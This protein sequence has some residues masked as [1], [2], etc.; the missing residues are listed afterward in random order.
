M[1][2]DFRSLRPIL[3][4]VELWNQ[5]K[6]MREGGKCIVD[7]RRSWCTRIGSNCVSTNTNTHTHF[8]SE[9][10]H[11][12]NDK[13]ANDI[14][15]ITLHPFYDIPHEEMLLLLCFFFLLM[16]SNAIFLALHLIQMHRW[17]GLQ[18]KR[19]TPSVP[20]VNVVSIFV[21]DLILLLFLS[22]VVRK[23]EPNEY[24]CSMR[25]PTSFQMRWVYNG[26][27]CTPVKCDEH[28]NSIIS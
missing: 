23:R 15:N 1:Q 25:P 6:A 28:Q 12:T 8:Q 19:F 21:Y 26:N 11:S 24:M 20:R 16:I 27:Q 7:L 5:L 18:C 17:I 10:K 2:L 9:R 13:T 22:L 4:L 3:V 14:Q